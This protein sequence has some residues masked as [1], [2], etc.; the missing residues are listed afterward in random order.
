MARNHDVEIERIRRARDELRHLSHL[1]QLP[2][3]DAEDFVR[4]AIPLANRSATDEVKSDGYFFVNRGW[5]VNDATN[6]YE[7]LDDGFST[8]VE[9][10]RQ[11]DEFWSETK[12]DRAEFLTMLRHLSSSSPDGRASINNFVAAGIDDIVLI[13]DVSWDGTELKTTRRYCSLSIRGL[14]SYVLTLM[15][16]GSTNPEKYLKFCKLQSCDCVF[17]ARTSGRPREYCTPEHKKA[18][19]AE[20]SPGRSAKSRKKMAEKGAEK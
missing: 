15:L 2:T 10:E 14:F 9:V 19:D 1:L 6:V 16:D 20:T 13:T 4:A 3:L 5:L 11:A 12:N 7:E 18:A 8:E 17:W